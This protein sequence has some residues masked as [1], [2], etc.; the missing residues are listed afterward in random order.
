M[1]EDVARDDEV[2]RAPLFLDAPGGIQSEEGPDGRQAA[3]RGLVREVRRLDAEDLEPDVPAVLQDQAVVAGDL[4]QERMPLAAVTLGEPRREPP[5]VGLR[6]LRRAGDPQVMA[7]EALRGDRFPDLD[8]AAL[9]A[10]HERQALPELVFR[11]ARVPDERVRQRQLPHLQQ[12]RHLL[13]AA[14]SA[15]EA[16]HARYL[17]TPPSSARTGEH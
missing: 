8:Q 9:L 11:S 13:L 17:L 14:G 7:E 15:L 3:A 16:L 2:G 1:T 12:D 6:R 4:D 5:R 10:H